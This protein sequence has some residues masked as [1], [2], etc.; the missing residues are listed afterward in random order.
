MSFGTALFFIILMYSIGSNLIYYSDKVNRKV[1]EGYKRL[2]EEEVEK[3][4]PPINESIKQ[5]EFTSVL[6]MLLM[7]VYTIG[8]LSKL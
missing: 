7:M 2:S 4:E 3:Y 8:I 6:F 5:D 1:L